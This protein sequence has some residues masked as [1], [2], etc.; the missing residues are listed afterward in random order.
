MAG[1]NSPRQFWY[2]AIA[3]IPLLAVVIYQAVDSSWYSSRKELLHFWKPN[4]FIKMPSQTKKTYFRT[5]QNFKTDYAPT[6]ITQYVSERTGMNVVVV[7]Q[8]GPQVNGYFALATE[9]FDDSGSPH[10]LEHLCFMGSKSY[11]YKGLLDK[12]AT[13]AY[14][15]T[16]AWT[17][18]DHTAYTLETAGWEG[19]SQILPVYLEHLIL[20]T[21][22][23]EGCYTEVH[24]VDG[25]GN[26]A[27]VVYSEM[28]GIQNTGSDIMDLRARQ[29]LYPENVGFRYETGGLMEN[30]RIL[31]PER[32]R[33]FH[34]E[35]YQPKNLCLVLIGEIDQKELLE[36]LDTFE[37]GI[38]DDIPSPTAPF[39]RPWVDSAQPP[40]LTKTIVET[41]YFP[42]EDESM[43]EIWVGMF[44]P[45]CKDAVET[46]ALNVLLAYLAGSSVSI[47]ENIMVEKEEL[48]SS[49]SYWWDA[50]PNSVIW[51]QPTGVET[52]KLA[53]VEKRLFE[54]LREA[55]EKPLDMAY[56]KNCL[57]RERRQCN[58]EAESSQRFYAE[59]II[60]DFLFGNRDGSTLKDLKSHAEFDTLDKWSEQQWKDFLKKWIVDAPH[61]S[62]LG[63]PSEEMSKRIK[64]EEEARVAERKEKLGP[65]GLKKLAE[66]LKT[67][68]AKNDAE[69][70]AS[71]LQKFSVPG[72]DSIHFHKSTTARS[73]LAKKLGAPTNEIQKVIDSQA[74]ESPLF[75]QFEHVPTNFVHLSMH[76][77]TSEIPLE[78]RP[79][80]SLF[81]DNFF[82]TPIFRDGKRVE[83]EQVVTELEHDTIRYEMRGGSSLGDAEGLMIQF[84]VEREKYETA[85]EWIR[86]M[87]FDGIFDATRLSTAVTKILADIPDNK[88]DGNGMLYTADGMLHMSNE[89]SMK[90]RTTLVKSV[91]MKRL[92]KLLK[93]EP[94]TVIGWLEALRKS[95]FKFNNIRALV[96]ADINKL[97]AP[98]QAWNPLISS[99]DKPTPETDLL[100][101]RKQHTL[102]S[103]DGQNLGQA[104]AIII[105]MPTSD[106]SFLLTNSRGPSSYTDP[107]LPALRVALS[108]LRAVEG[109]LWT[110]IR[111]TGLGYG[112]SFHN[113]LD[114]GFVQFSVYRS[115]D[116]FRAF[117][118][119]KKILEE[120]IS[121]EKKMEDSA[122]E[123]AISDIVVEVVN[124]QITMD[125]AGQDKFVK[126]VMKGLPENHN[127]ELL[128]KV[129]DV[130][131]EEIREVMKEV[132]LKAFEPGMSNVMVTCAPIMEEAI[133]KNFQSLN[134]KTQVR[135]LA[136]F[137]DDYGLAA[138]EDDEGG[139]EDE[140]EDED[141]EDEESGSEEDGEEDEESDVE[142]KN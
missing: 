83:F 27:G 43:G 55:L 25:E 125:Q 18:T 65:E 134:F 70:P 36:I 34:K 11:Q 87:M 15:N 23:E 73:G 78:H 133:V 118:A 140:D 4:S 99:L 82:D 126:G 108:F 49:I 2:M 92:K 131:R 14:S 100:P 16:N 91:Y 3:I 121:G 111:G 96:V 86:T 122:L 105:P 130:G 80:L 32:I 53:F 30:L 93:K 51:F 47:L 71:L 110:A 13:R 137:E 79:L 5:V 39:K 76:F 28:Q 119:G 54:L 129:R 101:I 50:R 42:E 116:A 115:P 52:E 128:R 66:K 19:F 74:S 62:L 35:M 61:V 56:M 123:A 7:D 95:I 58:F 9:I 127:E 45:D 38:L 41:V 17:A 31:T 75:L 81:I 103:H 89:S 77:G 88:R 132:L 57:E 120:Y 21:L 104:G 106:S 68:I 114:T 48:A 46:G 8:K 40:P 60:N 85:I 33:A 64:K 69:I 72:T 44:G 107:Q 67:A 138:P 102:L 136:S 112:S 10:T 20:P 6:N 141:M 113:D 90:A 97:P 135:T 98:V 24:H 37:E 12:L 124:T 117:A 29:L 142:M 22:T 1:Y 59:A 63:T 139:E 94:E 26:D 109:P 84:R